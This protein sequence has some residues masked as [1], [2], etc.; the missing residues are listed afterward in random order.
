M[1]RAPSNTWS[2][3]RCLRNSRSASTC[4]AVSDYDDWEL[5]DELEAPVASSDG[6]ALFR[7]FKPHFEGS[8][9]SL[10]LASKLNCAFVL[11]KGGGGGGE[12]G[13]ARA[14]ELAKRAAAAAAA[15]QGSAAS[16]GG[17]AG[18]KRGRGGD[19]AGAAPVHSAGSKR[20]AAA[21][22]H[23]MAQNGVT[24]DGLAHAAEG[25]GSSVTNRLASTS[26]AQVSCALRADADLPDL[27]VA[28]V[29]GAE[30][31]HEGKC[32]HGGDHDEETAAEGAGQGAAEHA[33]VDAA[34][35]AAAAAAAREAEQLRRLS[36]AQGASQFK[37]PN[38]FKRGR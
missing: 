24:D 14:K 12:G 10:V 2:I 33:H 27:P 19:A 3:R 28:H 11:R 13:A 30:G 7:R 9:P 17:A 22:A 34:V 32:G 23:A 6:S 38:R 25:L 37:R 8:H 21:T 15:G 16:G 5:D 29:S 31:A 36:G 1:V 18:V 4:H 35:E 20:P 26:A